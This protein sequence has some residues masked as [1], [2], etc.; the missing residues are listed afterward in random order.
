M[1]P[2]MAMTYSLR[3]PEQANRTKMVKPIIMNTPVSG[4]IKIKIIGGRQI[5]RICLIKVQS[6]LTVES[7][8]FF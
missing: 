2:I 5:L 3:I 7:G 1:T 8:Y 4:C 6:C